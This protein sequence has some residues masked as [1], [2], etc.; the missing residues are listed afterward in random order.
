MEPLR[1]EKCLMAVQGLIALLVV[2]GCSVN[3]VTGRSELV[4]MST[5]QEM[6]I[7]R[8]E[9]AKVSTTIGLIETAPIVSYIDQVGQRLAVQ[10]PR[11]EFLYEFYVVDMIEPNAFALPGGYIYISRG[12]LTLVNSEAELASVIGHEIGH[13][14]A[15]HA[16]QRQTR[17]TGVGLLTVLGTI[18]AGSSGGQQAAE[19]A[20]Q[21]GQIA[22]AGLISAYSRD[23]EREADAV[24]QQLAAHAG[25]EPIAMARFLDTLEK[26]TKLHGGS[27]AVPDY[28][29]SHPALSERVQTSTGRA[30]QLR[31]A[32]QA[33][34]ADRAG[35]LARF[36]DLIVGDD[37]AHGVFK[38]KLFLHPV[39]NVALQFPANW[40]TVNQRTVVAGQSSDGRALLTMHLQETA[41]DPRAAGADFVREHKLKV[42]S[43]TAT[44]IHG[45]RAYQIAGSTTA[46][47]NELGVL[48]TWIEHPNGIFRIAG[49]TPLASFNAYQG[50]F[51][52]AAAS[53]RALRDE[54]RTAFT[55]LRLRSVAARSSETL[56]ALVKRSNDR[57]SLQ[58]TAV[59]NGLPVSVALKP[60]ELIKI[61]VEQSYRPVASGS[62]NR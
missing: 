48:I 17:A 11:K 62:E 39:L 61:T 16:A 3:P 22:S 52:S 30:D 47:E 26:Y 49:A 41:R 44:N 20:S 32:P 6:E 56:Q 27:G 31:S 55:E 25:Y 33:P 4:L 60:G 9:A 5:Q 57:W 1:T 18:L 51:G 24:G 37:P 43:S 58:E 59:V 45:Y 53:F 23:Q 35:M 34:I 54:E 29:A 12:L 46:Q 21:I 40:P 50:I 10:S 14:A 19:A 42:D 28:F 15:R 38:N 13:V 2:A 7:G 8:Q 36:N